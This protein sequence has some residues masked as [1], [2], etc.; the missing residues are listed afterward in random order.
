MASAY[1]KPPYKAPHIE[2]SNRRVRVLFGGQTVVDTY[3]PKLVYA[4]TP[5]NQV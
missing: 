2:D 4:T 1:D 3:K 5:D